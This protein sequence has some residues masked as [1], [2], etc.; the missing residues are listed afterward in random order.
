MLSSLVSIAIIALCV[1]LFFYWVR[2][3]AA[4]IAE[5]RPDSIPEPFDWNSPHL[6][7]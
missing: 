6:S 2:V 5:T 3:T 7:L 4:L 1:P